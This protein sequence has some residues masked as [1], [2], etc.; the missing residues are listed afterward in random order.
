MCCCPLHSHLLL[1]LIFKSEC[2]LDATPLV[3]KSSPHVDITD[4]PKVPASQ[5]D[6]QVEGDVCHQLLSVSWALAFNVLVDDGD[7]VV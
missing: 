3:Q 1:L 7:D 2:C 6:T 4:V 5:V